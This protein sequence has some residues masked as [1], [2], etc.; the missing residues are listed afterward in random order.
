MVQYRAEVEYKQEK[1]RAA[2]GKFDGTLNRMAAMGWRVVSI[3]RV[4]DLFL[5]TFVRRL[6]Q[7]QQVRTTTMYVKEEPL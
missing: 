3:D 1:I 7:T 5:V 4:D 2:D 6:A